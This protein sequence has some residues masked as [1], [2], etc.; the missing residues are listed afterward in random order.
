MS[1]IVALQHFHT[2]LVLLRKSN[3]NI[4]IW[5]YIHACMYVCIRYAY[6]MSN[7]LSVYLLNGLANIFPYMAN[8]V[9][10]DAEVDSKRLGKPSIFHNNCETILDTTSKSGK[11]FS[12]HKALEIP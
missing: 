4:K 2:Y 11:M 5:N 6:S 12:L 1:A 3:V 7:A 8:L 9:W 10:R